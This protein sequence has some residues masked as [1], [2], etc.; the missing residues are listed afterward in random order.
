MQVNTGG[1]GQYTQQLS[2]DVRQDAAKTE[3]APA[4]VSQTLEQDSVTLSAESLELQ[5]GDTVTP[6][7]S[8]GTTLPPYPPKKEPQ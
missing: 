1:I 8:G 4:G 6:N 3:P 7:S 2:T 5:K